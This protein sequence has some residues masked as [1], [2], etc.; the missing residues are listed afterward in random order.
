MMIAEMFG[1]I[2]I[3]KKSNEVIRLEKE[4]QDL[5]DKNL[6]LGLLETDIKL[7]NNEILSLNTTIS[8][9]QK[10]ITDLNKYQDLKTYKAWFN[11]HIVKKP[12]YY[13]FRGVSKAAHTHLENF[14]RNTELIE[15]YE[16]FLVKNFF[17]DKRYDSP[18]QLVYELNIFLDKYVRRFP[19]GEYNSEM[20][21]FNNPEHW[22]S[23]S[24]AYDYYITKKIAG[25]CDDKGTF[26]YCCIVTALIYFGFWE[27]H[28]WRLKNFIVDI[29]TGEGH[30]LLG[31]LKEYEGRVVGYVP[32][33]STFRHDKFAEFWKKNMI[34][35]DQM[36][37]KIRFSF[38]EKTEYIM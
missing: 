2:F 21:I 38:D 7:A 37:Y 8:A 12:K 27:E 3:R 16:S 25:D 26:K 11:G 22:M 10:R 31:W 5:T 36:L 34:F 1:W 32:V 9:L 23:P 6:K 14:S 19:G 4:V 28:K 33:E 20:K 30:Y 15:K 24:E 35:K 29:I 13:S 18:D 17:Y